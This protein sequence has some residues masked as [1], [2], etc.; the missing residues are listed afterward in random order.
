V[1]AGVTQ[2][3]GAPGEIDEETGAT[4]R[5]SVTPS[6]RTRPHPPV[7]VSSSA[8]TIAFRA[9]HG[10]VPTCFTS[11]ASADPFACGRIESVRRQ[12]IEPWKVFPAK[13]VAPINHYAQTPKEVAIET[14][15]LFMHRITPALDEVIHDAH[16]ATA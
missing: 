5:V 7:F 4:R 6:P 10:F 12:M 2:R 13:H 16:R 1:R 8:E 9:K 15:D 14:L 3:F 11:I